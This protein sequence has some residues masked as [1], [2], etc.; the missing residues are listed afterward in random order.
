MKIYHYTTGPIMVNTYL[1]SDE[2]GTGFI[3][4]PG[5][6]S[7]PLASKIAEDHLKIPYIILTH[8]HADHIGG[9]QEFK[10]KFPEAKIV[11]CEDEKEVLMRPNLNS[12]MELYGRRIF[13]EA[14]LYVGEGDSLQVGEITLT[15]RK[16][17]GH[18]PGGMIILTDGVCFSGDTL[19]Q[20]SIGRTD[21]YGGDFQQLLESIRT[22]IYTLPDETIVLPGH[23]G[24]TTVGF[25]KENNPFV[26]I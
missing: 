7:K 21:F 1:V 23:M 15:F 17:P 9:V 4:D 10:E 6:Y 26:R 3:V 5:A 8:G 22:K 16:T 18:S 14:D 19:F 2:K 24:Q 20:A 13:I 25:E 12:S 11:A